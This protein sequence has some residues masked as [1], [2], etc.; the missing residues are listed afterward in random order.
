[1]TFEQAL[2]DGAPILHPDFNSY[3]GLPGDPLERPTNA[4]A[5]QLWEKGDLAEGFADADLILERSGIPKI[6]TELGEENE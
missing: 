3:Q 1:M 6:S 4:F 2:A 5:R